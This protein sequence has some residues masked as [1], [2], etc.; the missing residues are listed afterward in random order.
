MSRVENLYGRNRRTFSPTS[1]ASRFGMPRSAF[2]L[3][4]CVYISC[5]A[6]LQPTGPAA[7]HHWASRRAVLAGALVAA[8][9]LRAARA[10]DDLDLEQEKAAIERAHR[11]MP[12]AAP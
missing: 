5:C 8:T 12:N 11:T 10:A 3:C 7:M 2:M 4:S 6:A 9:P 1:S